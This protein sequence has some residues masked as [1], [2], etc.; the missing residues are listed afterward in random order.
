MKLAGSEW[1]VDNILVIVRTWAYGWTLF[2]KPGEDGI[3]VRLLVWTVG[4]DLVDFGF[5][6]RSENCSPDL[7]DLHDLW[8]YVSSDEKLFNKILICL[9]RIL[10]TL[11]PPPTAHNYSLGIDLTIPDRISRITDGRPFTARLMLYRNMYWLLYI[12]YALF[13]SCV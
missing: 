5:W 7:A 11:L 3:W 1:E 9:N 13:Y 8:A 6:G 12:T 4:Q 10:R 2:E